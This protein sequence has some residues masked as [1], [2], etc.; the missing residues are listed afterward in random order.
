MAAGFL[1]ISSSIAGSAVNQIAPSGWSRSMEVLT[2]TKG[3]LVRLEVEVG[4]DDAMAE[5]VLRSALATGREEAATTAWFP[6]R[7]GR[8][9]YGALRHL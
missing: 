5:D 2:S 7:F 9:E 4:N 1:P 8:S 6:I 3:L